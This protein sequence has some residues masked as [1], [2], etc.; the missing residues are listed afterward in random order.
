MYAYLKIPT[1]W[2]KSTLAFLFAITTLAM[3]ALISPGLGMD[4]NPYPL[5]KS[6]PSMVAY[7]QLKEDFTGNLE[8]ALVLLRH[9][10]SIYNPAT[11]ERIATLTTQLEEISLT[12][13][14]DEVLL[15]PFLPTLEGQ[16]RGLLEDI[17]QGG[18]SPEDDFSITDLQSLLEED[19]VNN[20][21]LDEALEELR[22]RMFPIKKV[23]SLAN[24]ENIISQED[25]LIVGRIYK[26]VPRGEEELESIARQVR[27]NELFSG[28]LI[29]ED[30]RS[31][32]ILVET[33]I[34]DDRA[35][36]MFALGNIIAAL[37]EETMLEE[38]LHIAGMPVMSAT[39]MHIMEQDNAVLFPIVIGLVGAILLLTF[40]SLRGVLLPMAVVVVSLIWTLAVMALLGIPLNMMTTALPVFLITVGVAD[41]IHMVSEFK[42]QFRRLGSRSGAVLEMLRHMIVPVVMTSITTGAG[43]IVLGYT[44]VK[45]IRE[46]GLFVALG[47]MMAMIVSLVLIPAALALG[48]EKPR[49]DGNRSIIPGVSRIED[50][51]LGIL[52]G[53]SELSIQH[54]GKILA[55]AMVI[56]VLALFGVTQL[57]VDNDFVT[58]FDQKSPIVLATEALDRDLAGSNAANILIT[59]T[60]AGEEPFKDPAVLA[61]VEGLQ[62]HLESSLPFVRKSMSL[63]DVLKRINLVMH[64]NDPVFNRLPGLEGELNGAAESA[65]GI[66]AVKIRGRDLVAQ[67]LL[68]YENGGGENLTDFTDSTF[69]TLNVRVTLATRSTVAINQ[70]LESI[71]EYTAR[72]FPPG[73]EVRFAGNAELITATNNEI[74]RSQVISLSVSF[75]AILLLLMALYRSPVKALFAVIPLSVA[76]VV[77]FGVM[78]WFGLALNIGTALISSIVIGIGVDFAIHYMSRLKM[79][80]ETH[81]ELSSAI[82]AT[83]E[84]SGKAIT[85][86]A[87]TVAIGFMAMLLSGFVPM[88]NMGWMIAQM[89]VITAIATIVLL[90]AAIA[91]F[92]PKFA[93]VTEDSR[94]S[95]KLAA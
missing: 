23:T 17:L 79:E 29:S 26:D 85:A 69:S 8:T 64:D 39:A 5:S 63:T 60:Q 50:L 12:G 32:G 28:L 57:R 71:S 40:R 54:R 89:L 22:L 15:T 92:N 16:Q 95:D 87:I 78:G 47:V 36:L 81:G 34:P 90:P 19:G 52:V 83:M 62:R 13:T 67:Y 51:G 37:A 1:R 14:G 18:I 74:L 21:E 38:E 44:D 76:I 20:S 6:H 48:R 10:R 24:V 68:L 77:N 7:R 65:N 91:Y 82:Q 86:N 72:N 61:K 45:P 58:Y 59:A 80:L 27:E 93:R 55:G 46:F 30:E 35:E 53:V 43:F 94:D 70:V 4:P 73:M 56:L 84:S 33:F 49:R 88:R 9:P 42:D 31:T 75:A 41:G 2:P 3:W 25:D 66:P 11:L